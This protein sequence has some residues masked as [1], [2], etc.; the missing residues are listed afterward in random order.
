MTGQKSRAR[1]EPFLSRT[2]CR[3]LGNATI[4]FQTRCLHFHPPTLVSNWSST[5]PFTGAKASPF[6]LL[7][8]RR[9]NCSSHSFPRIHVGQRRRPDL[10]CLKM[11][12]RRCS[13]IQ[14]VISF[15]E[16]VRS[17]TVIISERTLFNICQCVVKGQAYQLITDWT[18]LFPV[19]DE[20]CS[21]ASIY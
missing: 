10:A 21:H 8:C 12:R 14:R 4:W 20:S 3:F 7:S 2:I 16:K 5:E 6:R 9:K 18:S 1:R 11:R 15:G 17:R 19:A 13:T